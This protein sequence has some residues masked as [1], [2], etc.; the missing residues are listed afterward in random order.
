MP[1]PQLLSRKTNGATAAQSSPDPP[2]ATK[3]KAPVNGEKVVVRRL[4][5]GMTEEEFVTILGDEWK[6]G[7]GKV[8]W[9]SYCPGKVSQHPSKPSIPA[10][11]YLHVSQ[12]DQ[13][14][15]LLRTV[16][17]AKW[18]DAKET[19]NDPALVAPPTVE[20]SIFKKIPSDK[21]RV[22][23]RQ[24]TIDQDPEFMAFLESL[25]SP[26]G[27]KEGV[28][29]EPEPEEEPEKATTTPL[30]EYLKE[31]KAAKAKEAAAAKIAMK[32]ARTES[33]SGKGKAPATSAEEPKRRSTRESRTE[34]TTEK[35]PEKPRE[36]VKI[37][38]KKVV[39]AAE[40]AAE[41]AKVAAIQKTT[42]SSAASA[43]S[44]APSKSRRAGI[45]AA[46]RILQRDLG[47]SSSN[48]HRKARMDAAKADADSKGSAAKGPA[49]E[50]IPIAPEPAPPPPPAQPS[51][52]APPKSQPA[53]PSNRSR[54]RKRGGG[55]EGG[56]SKGDNKAD[57]QVDTAPPAPAPTPVKPVLLLKKRDA[58]P[59]QPQQ[60]STPATPVSAT[61]PQT[62]PSTA[63]PSQPTAPKNAPAKQ[64]GGGGSKKN[65]GPAPSSGATR[66]F[67]KHANHSQGV[68]EALLKEALSA[69]GTVTSVD[70]DRKKG[71]AY[72]DFADHAGLAKAMAASPVTVAQATVQVLERK[73]MGAKKG[74]QSSGSNQGKNAAASASTTSTAPAATP[75]PAP[76]AAA[77]SSS[78]ATE[79]ASG[80]QQPRESKRN[81]RH[82]NKRGRDNKD[83]DG[84]EG[85]G[86]KSGGGGGG[87]TTA[88][89]AASG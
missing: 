35:A 40:A 80:E 86:G 12:R 51:S 79:K 22:D 81:P 38:T 34:R 13:L 56:K 66:A 23:G 75:A 76:A 28:T 68:T 18:E 84:K 49:K 61:I 87:S 17:E 82:R 15:D 48:A 55:D 46:A 53:A 54:N 52:S 10:R 32:H 78:T 1:T 7:S 69:Y 5:P 58:A 67:V 3:A 85:A 65:A 37:L 19:Y 83:K 72:V 60:S 24:G 33:L 74:G 36:S 41:A 25:A 39:A 63:G 70:I 2:K 31:R 27:N 16:Q 62:A 9:F 30:I 14:P 11:A 42:Q 44:E 29:A 6:I 50:N 20:F 4:P 45:A 43:S 8:G 47:L 88:A 26:D 71:F 73:D 21:K 77:A 64:G 89:A 57:K 59:P